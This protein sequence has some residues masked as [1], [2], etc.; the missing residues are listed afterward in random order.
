[1][2]FLGLRLCDHD[3]NITYTDG[4]VV[5]Y[6]KSERIH[7]VKH[8]GYNDFS[9]YIDDIKHWNINFDELD[10]V[11][12][13]VDQHKLDFK[14]EDVLWQQAP[15]FLPG[16]SCPVY[17]IDHHYAHSLSCWPVVDV[18]TVDTAFVFDGVG[19][20]SITN[21][22]FKKDECISKSNVSGVGVLLSMWGNFV[23]IEGHPL[24][25]S[26]KVMALKS[27]GRA[28][29]EF[30]DGFS[31]LSIL[32]ASKVFNLYNWLPYLKADSNPVRG[33][34]PGSTDWI[35]SIHQ[36]IEDK[37]PE[38]FLKFANPDDVITFSGGV[39]Q[40]ICVNSRLKKIFKNLHIIPHNPDDGLSL[41][42]V[43]F[44]RRKFDQPKFNNDNFPFWQ[45]ESAPEEPSNETIETVAQY[46]AE[47]KIVGWFQGQ[48][49]VGPRA[50]GNRS[51]LMRPDMPDGK[52]IINSRVKF[53]EEYR[54]FGCSVLE[55]HTDEYFDCDYSSPYMLYSVPVKNK[56]LLSAITHIDGTS[57]IQ[58]VNES[59]S[60]FY[61]LLTNFYKKTNMP[62]LLNTSLNVNKKP[63]AS[64]S[65][66]AM[67]LFE[68][69]DLDVLCI[70]NKIFTR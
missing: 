31:N 13:C 55:E 41:G 61:K 63:I 6:V 53:R 62:V 27:Y 45:S 18:D 7:Q 34:K 51:I 39:A 2:K 10:A 70:G 8:H 22:I 20:F 50:L 5:R 35:A 23:G 65:E 4:T 30:V 67:G 64:T 48:G 36:W 24:D 58:T 68:T 28:N 44:L 52:D 43:E 47:G 21:S 42:C 46:L 60:V 19:D 37:M 15:N 49:E 29:K 38:Y 66:H 9:S 69:T 14:K 25:V 33:I 54:P 1:M 16:I 56:E 17:I 40:N 12:I 59:Q 32:D 26:G 57:R 11:A 3:S